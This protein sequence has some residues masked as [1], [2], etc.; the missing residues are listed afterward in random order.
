MEED[1]PKNRD[2][3]VH[4]DMNQ[5]ETW[6]RQDQPRIS[7]IK[8]QEAKWLNKRVLEGNIPGQGKHSSQPR[9]GRQSQRP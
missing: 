9:Q 8:I 4:E 1:D 2:Q 6:N 5:R 7:Q 3:R